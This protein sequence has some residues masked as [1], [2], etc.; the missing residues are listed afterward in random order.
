MS[1]RKG[2]LMISIITIVKND[3][4]NLKKTVNSVLSQTFTDYEFL[5]QDGLSEDGTLEWIYSIKDL[6]KIKFKSEKDISLYDA[7]NKA[8]LRAEGNYIIFLNAGDTF[9]EQESL[10]KIFNILECSNFTLNELIVC[11]AIIDYGYAQRIH[12]AVPFEDWLKGDR[13]QMPTVHQA[14]FYPRE[15]FEKVG[16]YDINY[17][18][19]GDYEHIRRIVKAGY[20]WKYISIPLVRYNVYGLANKMYWQ[21]YKER[22]QIIYKCDGKRKA[23]YYTLS[24]YLNL[25]RVWFVAYARGKFWYK[26]LALLRCNWLKR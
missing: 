20:K 3:L 2:K 4:D 10:E 1:I 17:G 11:D 7:M 12:K 15:I 14:I 26:Y 18:I 19:C 21:N 16:G 23:L 13:R 6:Y 5:I 9:V 25:P 8:I 24:F 22:R